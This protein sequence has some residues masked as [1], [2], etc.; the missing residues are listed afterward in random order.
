MGV[1]FGP[2]WL[3]SEFGVEWSRVEWSRMEKSGGNGLTAHLLKQVEGI[4][5]H[6]LPLLRSILP[7]MNE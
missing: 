7:F 6:Y 5:L 4:I 2:V 1:N 3:V